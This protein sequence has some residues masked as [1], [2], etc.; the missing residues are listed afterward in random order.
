VKNEKK[1]KKDKIKKQKGQKD[2]IKRQYK[3]GN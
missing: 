1:T 2:K 3:F